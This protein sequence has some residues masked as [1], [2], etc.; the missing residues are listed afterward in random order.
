MHKVPTD[1]DM[2]QTWARQ[3]GTVR[4]GAGSLD[5]VDL[6]VISKEIKGLPREVRFPVSAKLQAS[7]ASFL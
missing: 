7:M 1:P 5:L 3:E 6:N 4:A 2:Q